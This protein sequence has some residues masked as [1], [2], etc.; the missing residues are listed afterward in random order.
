MRIL[1]YG[2]SNTYGYDPRSCLGGRYPESVRWTALLEAKGLETVN[3]GV[4][5]RAI[6]RLDWEI[7]GVSR[8]IRQSNPEILVVM[9][10]TNDLLRGLT[11]EACSARMERFLAALLRSVPEGLAVLLTAPPPIKPG[12]WA[13]NPTLIGESHR[14]AGC[15]EALAQKLNIR[16]AD[17]GKWGVEPA[18]DGV[19]FSGEGH[20]AF[21]KGMLETLRALG[22]AENPSRRDG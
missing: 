13:P 22:S 4:N 5:G 8:A 14:L 10:G 12:D 1:C 3:G 7:E 6:P 20:R 21:A 19:H 11:A 18:F 17:A 16:F 15:Y 9:L 2:D